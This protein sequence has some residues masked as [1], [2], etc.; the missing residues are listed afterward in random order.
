METTVNCHNKKCKK[1]TVTAHGYCLKTISRHPS[2]RRCNFPCSFD[3]EWCQNRTLI[4]SICSSY[5]CQHFS[6]ELP[7]P[8]QNSTAEAM[9]KDLNTNSTMDNEMTYQSST[10]VIA[11]SICLPILALLLIGFLIFVGKKK[12]RISNQTNPNYV[13]M[14]EFISNDSPIVRE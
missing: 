8:A 3:E 12:C 10:S 1:I 7:L 2:K 11:L 14:E 4:T 5:Q 6:E 13:E 9:L